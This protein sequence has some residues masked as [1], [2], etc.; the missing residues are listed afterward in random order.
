MPL[1]ISFFFKTT[2]WKDIS[3][4]HSKTKQLISVAAISVLPIVMIHPLNGHHPIVEIHRGWVNPDAKSIETV[5][6]HWKSGPNLYFQFAKN[7]GLF[8]YP[9]FSADRMLNFWSPLSWDASG[10]YSK[11]Y[12]WSSFGQASS[13]PAIL[14]EI[15]K[16]QPITIV[17][18]NPELPTLVAN[19]CGP[20]ATKFKIEK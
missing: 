7:D 8:E 17:T 5:I 4:G 16:S 20:T 15:I 2:V 13:D 1:L 6:N 19:S 3:T 10:E 14:C 9:S 11:F 18:R 12:T